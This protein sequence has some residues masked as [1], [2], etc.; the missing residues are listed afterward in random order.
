M[1][2]PREPLLADAGLAEHEERR[3]RLADPRRATSSSRRISGLR[4]EK[5]SRRGSDAEASRHP[6]PTHRL[7]AA[8]RSGREGVA[9]MRS[10]SRRLSTARQ[11]AVSSRARSTGSSSV[12]STMMSG[13]SGSRR[14]SVTSSTVPRR[15]RWR[16]STSRSNDSR[17]RI[18]HV[19]ADPVA[20]SMTDVSPRRRR[21]R[22]ASAWFSVTRRILRTHEPDLRSGGYTRSDRRGSL[23]SHPRRL[24][25]RAGDDGIELA[26]VCGMNE[27]CAQ[28][29]LE[30]ARPRQEPP[31]AP[32]RSDD[33]T[34]PGKPPVPPTP[35]V[36]Q[37]PPG[38][39]PKR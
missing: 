32:A 2:R 30:V 9:S 10:S 8:E 24:R 33:R 6:G 26:P 29:K 23:P 7:L 39:L 37:R 36:A 28:V 38:P 1:D 16:P 22:R 17:A 12:C 3:V 25:S 18:D 27:S 35:P 21:S 19:A 4:D 34:R 5:S 14:S 20:S 31:R 11:P 13:P 15:G